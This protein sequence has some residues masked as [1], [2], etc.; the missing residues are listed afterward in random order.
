MISAVFLRNEANVQA[1][2][3]CRRAYGMLSSLELEMK[4]RKERSSDGTQRAAV[5]EGEIGKKRSTAS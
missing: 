5:S 3:S 1:N 2:Q 4:R